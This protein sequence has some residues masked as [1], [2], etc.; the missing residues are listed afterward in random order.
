LEINELASAGS[1]PYTVVLPDVEDVVATSNKKRI[2]G[3]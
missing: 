2:D 3:R 1:L